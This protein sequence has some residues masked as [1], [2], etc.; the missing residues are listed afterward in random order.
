MPRSAVPAEPGSSI[1]HRAQTWCWSAA[2]PWC[3]RAAGNGWA[4]AVDAVILWFI[5]VVPVMLAFTLSTRD[6]VSDPACF[7]EA[8]RLY[9][10]CFP[11]ISGFYLTTILWYPVVFGYWT[12]SN[13]LGASP[14]KLAVGIR[15]VRQDGRRPGV[16]RG[17]ARTVV[18]IAS[19]WA[20]GLGYF[21]AFWDQQRQTWHDKAAGTYVMRRLRQ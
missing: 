3:S 21:W 12:V 20:L 4:D 6:V 18:S 1:R 15:I 17:L 9:D 8:G 5:L 11:D 16:G 2:R 14:G 10:E 7:D 19:A 13:A